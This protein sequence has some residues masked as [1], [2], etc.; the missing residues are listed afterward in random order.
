M[1]RRPKFAKGCE[2]F[3]AERIGSPVVLR[4]WRAGDR[5]QPIGMK[6]PVKL[7]DLFVNHKISRAQRHQLVV[8]TTA[9]GEPFWVEGLRVADGF[10]LDNQTV[11][12]LKWR[13]L[14]R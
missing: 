7:Q 1:N 6:A 11:R 14:R 12:R 2:H 5:F 9:K 4:H 8:A 3:D 13:W 10:K